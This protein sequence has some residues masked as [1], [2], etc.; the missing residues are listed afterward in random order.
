MNSF[1]YMFDVYGRNNLFT[2]FSVA[3]HAKRKWLLAH[4]YSKSAILKSHP[5]TI[6]EDKINDFLWLLARPDVPGRMEIFSTLHYYS[7][8]VITTFLYGT[9]DSGATTALRSTPEHLKLLDDIMDHNRKRLS[10]FAVHMPCLVTWMYT[11]TGLSERLVKPILPMQKP[12]TY[13]SIRA[14]ALRAME[15]YRDADTIVRA[16]AQDSTIARLWQVRD[17]AGLDDLDIASESADQILA[18]IDTTSDTLMFL[19]RALPL[20]QYT[21]IQRKLID[22]FKG[23]DP[24]L[25]KDGVVDL[26]AADRPLYLVAVIKETL[27]LYAPL[28]ASEPRTSPANTIIDGYSTPRGTVCSAAPHSLHRKAEIFLSPLNWNPERW[29][30]DDRDPALVEMKKWWRLFSSGARMCLGLQ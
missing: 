3:G 2:F 25:V 30:K 21:H 19:I 27:R 20:P 26:D 11:R 13:S 12:A 6:T 8:D 22:E 18:G 14:H 24:S 23:I 17:S 5:A 7:I 1:Y 29:S 28:P 9:T 10:W 4:A 16:K 15:Q